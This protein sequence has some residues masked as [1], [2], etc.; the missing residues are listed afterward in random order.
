MLI[1]KRAFQIEQSYWR[2]P[3]SKG[4]SWSSR[5][6]LYRVIAD[7]PYSSVILLKVVTWETGRT[8]S[9]L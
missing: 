8:R 4:L 3:Y 5:K 2:L 7:F 6:N 9:M 1:E